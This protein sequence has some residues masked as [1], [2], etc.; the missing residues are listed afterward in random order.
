MRT[1]AIMFPIE[2]NIPS[3][4]V[5]PLRTQG[6]QNLYPHDSVVGIRLISPL[7]NLP[8]S[9]PP[10]GLFPCMWSSVVLD[11]ES[12]TQLMP[13]HKVSLA[14]FLANSILSL[15]YFS[16][17]SMFC[18][19]VLLHSPAFV[20]WSR[21]KTCSILRRRLSVKTWSFL[22]IALKLSEP[23]KRKN[24]CIRKCEC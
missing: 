16:S 14:G 13:C 2:C 8:A 18:M 1:R 22:V 21:Q 17:G 6:V 10:W 4:C 12:W 11:L 19:S 20:L 24:C 5:C 9:L 15:K 7:R 23:Y 3:S